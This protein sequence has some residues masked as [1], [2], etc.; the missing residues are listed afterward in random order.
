MSI[1]YL[2]NEYWKTGN[3]FFCYLLRYK[4]HL[5]E[6]IEKQ[7]FFKKVK[8]YNKDKEDTKVA[9]VVRDRHKIKL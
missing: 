4:V 9:K 1:Q 6:E 2:I 8:K 3:D 5:S 7:T